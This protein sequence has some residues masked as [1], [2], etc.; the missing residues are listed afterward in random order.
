MNS[1]KIKRYLEDYFHVKFLVK[2]QGSGYVISFDGSNENFFYVTLTI[3]DDIRLII[4]AEP[5]KYG[6]QFVETINKSSKDERKIFTN[7]WDCLGENKLVIK[8][9]DLKIVKDAFIN[10]NQVWNYFSLRYSISPYYDEN[11]KKEFNILDSVSSIIS[12]ILSISKY[13]IEGYSEGK[14]EITQ[15][16]RYER[17]PINRKLCLLHKGYKCC[18]CGFD[19]EK[20]FGEIGKNFIEVHHSLPVSQMG[21]NHVVD[22]LKEL[23]PLCSNCHSMIHKKIP[24][25]TVEELKEIK[26]RNKK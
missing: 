7:Y 21:E 20:E 15:E 19:F 13:S 12:M 1:N 26:N 6:K 4:F 18:V 23:Y 14:K 11:E 8:I 2:P 5:E 25:F 17:N 22:P 3:K 10:D 16:Q 24:P 9:N